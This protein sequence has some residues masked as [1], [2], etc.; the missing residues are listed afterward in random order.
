MISTRVKVQLYYSLVLAVLLYGTETWP[1]TQSTT[2]KLEAAHHRWLRK[3]LH[4]SL[5][6]KVTNENVRTVEN[7]LNKEY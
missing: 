1:M 5:K 7:S 2:I 6:D 4:I 3:I